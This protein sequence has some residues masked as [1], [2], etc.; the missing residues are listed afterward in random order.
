[1]S[2]GEEIYK[3]LIGYLYDDYKIKPSHKMLPKTKGCVKGYDGQ[4]K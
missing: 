3:Y 4:I 1:M 2:F